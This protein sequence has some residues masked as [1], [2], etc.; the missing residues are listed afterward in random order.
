MTGLTVD[1]ATSPKANLASQ[2][3]P[4]TRYRDPGDVLHL[5]ASGTA[6]LV[7]VAIVA[8]FPDQ[9]VGGDASVVTGAEPDTESGRLLVG[10]VQV[11]SVGSAAG[12]A[13]L[14]LWRRR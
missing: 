3:I 2:I 5:L 1:E 11:L 8:I 13:A 6:V 4:P 14:L 7:T 10:V 9:L 12:L